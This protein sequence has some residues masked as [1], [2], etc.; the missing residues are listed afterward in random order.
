MVSFVWSTGSRLLSV[1]P[2]YIIPH[3]AHLVDAA[4]RDR[5]VSSTLAYVLYLRIGNWRIELTKK[6]LMAWVR[7]RDLSIDKALSS[8]ELHS[9][10]L[11][12]LGQCYLIAT[13]WAV[14]FSSMRS[15]A[16]SAKRLVSPSTLI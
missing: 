8:V 14:T 9:L 1:K 2:K 5:I 16:T 4:A 11:D 12:H 15:S 6:P 10:K 3:L 7:C 13:G